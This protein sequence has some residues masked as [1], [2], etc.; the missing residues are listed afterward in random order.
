VI[1]F[2]DFA[3]GIFPLAS[4]QAT[5][6]DKLHFL[7]QCLDLDGS[8]AISREDVLVHLHAYAAQS[9]CAADCSFSH[10]P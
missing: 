8:H 4:A 2:E 5:L 3:R 9:L 7:F 1:S 10:E 6:D